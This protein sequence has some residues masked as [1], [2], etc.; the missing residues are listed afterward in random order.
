MNFNKLLALCCGICALTIFVTYFV[1]YYEALESFSSELQLTVIGV[2]TLGFLGFLGVL[3]WKIKEVFS[4]GY[5]YTTI[6]LSI[7]SGLS[8]WLN[9]FLYVRI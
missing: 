2:S 7:I 9:Y 5:I 3:I 8:M 1:N 4:K 6:I